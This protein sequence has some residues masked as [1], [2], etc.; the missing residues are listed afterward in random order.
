MTSARPSRRDRHEPV[1]Q[2]QVGRNRPE[3]L[4][5][6]PERLHVDELEAVALGQRARLRH[7]ARAIF[8]RLHQVR[9]VHQ[10]RIGHVYYYTTELS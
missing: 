1:A 2:H 6:D 8:R 10:S 5:I 4:L 3:Q 7:F 9:R